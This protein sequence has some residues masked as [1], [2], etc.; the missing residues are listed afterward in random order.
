[1][2]VF[3]YTS[4]EYDADFIKEIREVLYR[5]YS[6]DLLDIIVLFDKSSKL[7]TEPPSIMRILSPVND[8][9]STVVSRIKVPQQSSHYDA[10]GMFKF[11]SDMHNKQIV[12]LD[13]NLDVLSSGNKIINQLIETSKTNYS[14][15]GLLSNPF[16]FLHEKYNIYYN[17]AM[18]SELFRTPI[19][20]YNNIEN[21]KVDLPF[22]Q[23]SMG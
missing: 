19:D 11:L 14:I 12:I 3:I 20:K 9:D 10:L 18:L 22:K 23:V 6:F 15:G 7:I 16:H 13:K 17:N 1:M 8:Q 2:Q 5:D 21:T 4:K